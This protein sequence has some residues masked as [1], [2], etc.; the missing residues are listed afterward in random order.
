M[1]Y[2]PPGRRGGG[3]GGGSGNGRGGA[4]GSGGGNGADGALLPLVSQGRD[5]S[6][7]ARLPVLSR[8]N[9]PDWALLMRV[10]LQAQGLWTAIDP[11]YAEFREDRA[12]LSA[13]LQAVP[14]EMLRG[15][16][17][18]D[19]AKAAW[20]AIKTMRVGVDRVREAK[21]QGFRRQFESMRFKERETPEEFA[22]RLTAVV[23][24]IRDMGG[25]MEDEHVNKKLLRVVPKKYK[26]VAISLE[27]LL[28]V[29][30]MALEELVGRLSTVDSYSDDEEG[31]DGGKLYLTEEQWQ[32]RVKQREQ[33]GSGNSGNK[34]RGAPGTQNHR[35]KPGGSPKGKEAATGANSSRDISRVK[36][37]NCDEFGHYARQCRKPRRQRRGEA[38]LVQAAEEEPTLLMAH[39]VGVSLAGEA[40]L[41]RTPGGQEVHLTEKK[42]ILDHEDGGEEEVT[43]DWFLD[44]GA[45][46]HMTG[47][48]SAF[49]E[50][51]TGVVGTVKFGDGSV[52]EIQGR[53][54]VVF[55]CKNGDHRSLDTVYYI[56]K[57]R[58]NIISV[59]RLDARGYDAH[60]WGGVCTLRDPDGLLLAKVKRDI[61]YLYILKLHIANPVCMAASGGDT[62][63]RWHA[64][65]GHLNFQSLR[66]LAQGNMVRGL[67][68]I[69]HTDQLCDGCLA[70][71]QRRL[72]FPEEAKFRAQEALELVHGDLCGPIT[73]ATPG[74]RKYFLLL[75]DDMSRH[76]WIRLLSGKH[77][78][79][80][81]I[82]QFQVGVELE[83]GR[84]LRALRTDR[85]GEFTS[86]E[87]MDYCAD[88]GMRRELTAPY[89]PQQN[90]VVERRNQT[91]VAAARSMLKAA[92]M[93]ACFWGEA[94]VAAV[95]VLNR[96][97]TK[98]LNGVTP[99]EA[100]HGRRPSVE[101]LRVFGCVGY[102]KTV[103]PNLRKLDDRGTRMVFIGYEQGSKAYRMYDPVARRVC[104]SRDVVFDE[105]ATWAWRDP[106]TE[107]TEEEE[108][109]VDFFVNPVDSVVADLG[110]QASTPVQGGTYPA[111]TATPPSPPE[112]PAGVEFCS[113]PNSVT[114]GT[115]E[116]PIR[117]RR[118]QD[119]L[120]ATEPVLD[121]DYSDQCLLASEE[122]MSLAEAEQ[123]LCW[124]QAMQEE[125]KSIED[126]QTWSF[127]E[128]PVGHKAIGL[129][130]VYKVKK[131]PSGVVVKHKARLVAKGYVQQQGIDFE[132]VFAPVARMETVRLLIAVAANKGWEIHHM[133]VKSAFLNGDLEEEVYVVQPP[134]FIEK[135]KEGQVLR[136]KKALYGLK[137]APRAWNAKLHNTLISLNFIKSETESA[138]YVRG[139]GSSRLIVGVYVD[140]LIIS[141]AQASEI[142]FF[143]EEMKKKFRMSDLGLLSY[144]L[145]MEVVQKDDGVFLSQTAYAAKILEKTGMEGCNSTQVPMEARLKL[146]RESGGE[147]VDSTMYRST[148]GSLRYLVNTRPDLAYSV[149]YVSRFMEKPTSEHWAA[150]KHILRY[151]AGT[152]DVGCW[153]GRREKGELRLIG[154]SDSDMAG[155]LDDRK[156][157]TGV[158]YMLGDS[159]ISWQ[160]QK[161]KV[162]ALSSCEAE[163]I[164]AT[165]GACQGIWLNRLLAELLGEDPGQTVMKVDN[166]S[167]I[168]LCKNPVLH[169]RSKHIDTRFHFIRECVEK[170]QIAVEYVRT[171]DQLADILTKPVGR[172][173]FLELRKKMGLEQAHQD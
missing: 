73:P 158:L 140:D 141:G 124:R 40:T 143:K 79:A 57:L 5:A 72:P 76:M 60:I 61:N 139:T 41:G 132:E 90:G 171:E 150:V 89:S 145:G 84:K 52:I 8:T 45:T 82:K 136:L 164:A 64:R 117:Y 17:K 11:G 46:N 138:V 75:V 36:C 44:T 35:G 126:N 121:F 6:H 166:K 142:D 115:N 58:K 1:S 77:E 96:S 111:S 99:H 43:R 87:F 80:T 106:E 154:F 14:R 103:K 95:Y 109:T 55:R 59:G 42:V 147:G 102:V 125:L 169:D 153:F 18:H 130:W 168:N 151:I 70:G 15:L 112:V 114:P 9:Y 48:R 25:V 12:A 23:A 3:G 56:P 7:T 170:K 110:E 107:A 104:V 159:L 156:S 65:F 131:D 78:A 19:T 137:Q 26:P 101:H 32:A 128:L 119:I 100:W 116:G 133:D 155:D 71:K 62:A 51:D 135:G 134:G 13:I 157:T 83:S 53:G 123:Q 39:V 165:T 172:V 97:P 50:L 74:G 86:V 28:D 91:V 81:A 68:I 98:A 33:E 94:V 37:F 24:D 160:S 29:K 21:E 127:A 88:H 67:P 146:K 63:R 49:A 31:S 93:P 118:V 162:V 161:Q 113:P 69:D 120:S 173:R 92:G 20:D 22:M 105:A 27:Q 47:V 30:T 148:V 152:L 16:A 34:G 54:T 10:N 108:F 129:K 144:Y 66:R 4:S 163:Y 149:G 167:A 85:G 38:N 122:P 2:T